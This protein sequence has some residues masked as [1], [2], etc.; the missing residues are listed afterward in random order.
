MNR[1]RE[2]Y[3]S[4]KEGRSVSPNDVDYVRNSI[5][6]ISPTEIE[7]NPQSV[8]FLVLSFGLLLDSSEDNVR[9]IEAILNAS[10]TIGD[11]E[12]VKATLTTICIYWDK[13][14]SILGTLIKIIDEHDPHLF[15]DSAAAAANA[16]S[17]LTM[18]DSSLQTFDFLFDTAL[19]RIQLGDLTRAEPYVRAVLTAA[20]GVR[21]ISRQEL[22]QYLE[23]SKFREI[24]PGM[25]L[26]S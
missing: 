14:R 13:A 10:L 3:L 9:A 22:V 23:E 4:I 7:N 1:A 5:C 6:G 16:L 15:E 25:K 18:N 2:I 26:G 24:K 21:H 20:T 8:Y 17:I 19:R 12:V 11:D